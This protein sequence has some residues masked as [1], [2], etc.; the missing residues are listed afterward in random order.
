VLAV[1][2]GTISL[3]NPEMQSKSL[4]CLAESPERPCGPGR[5]GRPPRKSATEPHA[6]FH[7]LALPLPNTPSAQL[8]PILMEHSAESVASS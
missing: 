8:M 3:R 2:K 6:Q 1:R 7:G 5:A 4:Q